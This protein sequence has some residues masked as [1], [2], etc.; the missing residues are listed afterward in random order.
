MSF[1]RERKGG[2][3]NQLRLFFLAVQTNWIKDVQIK[4]S[5]FSRKK[6]QILFFLSFFYDL[7]YYILIYGMYPV[8]FPFKPLS[9]GSPRTDKVH[10]NF[11]G[12][13]KFFSLYLNQQ[14]SS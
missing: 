4:I 10:G 6:K 8:T 3:K 13:R 2:E 12:L 1:H 14:V 9:T 7:L 5:Q 11:D